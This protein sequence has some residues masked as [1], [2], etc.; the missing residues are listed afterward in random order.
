MAAKHIALGLV[1][2]LLIFAS[3]WY[4]LPIIQQP[5]VPSNAVKVT[6]N[7]GQ[8]TTVSI[9]GNAYCFAYIQKGT[10]GLDQP[11][12]CVVKPSDATAGGLALSSYVATAGSHYG[13]NIYGQ[14]INVI[15]SEVHSDYLVLEVT[16]S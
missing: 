16:P 2:G 10:E 14:P 11:Y 9:A 8:I 15:V 3:L 12:F 13:I 1:I 5:Q 4:V 7:G 6:V